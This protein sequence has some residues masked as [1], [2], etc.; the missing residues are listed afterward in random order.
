[1]PLTQNFSASQVLGLPN[2]I[3]LTD[4]ST[5]SDGAVTARRVYPID[6]NGDTVLQEGTTTAYELWDNFP[7]TTT[8][9]LD[10]LTRDTALNIRV[11]WV[12]SGGTVL[13]TKTVGSPFV[14]Y[15]KTYYIFLLKCQSS[16]PSLID[17]ANFYANMVKLLGCIKNATDSLTLIDDIKSSQAAMDSAYKLIN[18]P[19]YFF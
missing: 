18:N 11:D 14:L 2:Q 4:E 10:L 15:A 6:S 1:M 5:G 13:Y 17:N 19:S 7:G 9:T 12:N 3:V 16:R 8:L